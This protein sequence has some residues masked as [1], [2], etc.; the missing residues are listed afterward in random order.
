MKYLPSY[1]LVKL[2][3]TRATKLE[4]LDDC[5]LP[6]EPGTTAY[7][8]KI[9]VGGK[10]V[11][12]TVKRKQYP[13]T[14]AYG[15]TDY[16][17]QGQTIPYVIVDIAI[18]PTGGL[19]LFNLYVALSRSSGRSTIRLL[20]NFDDKLFEKQHDQILLQEDER[21]DEKDRQTQLWYEQVIQAHQSEP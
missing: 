14:A 17:S 20:R 2:T 18:P 11:Q 6:I 13:L 16:R 8:I 15:F 12:R 5:V 3:R 19:N 21:L 1:L 4:G 9:M 7:R 10:M